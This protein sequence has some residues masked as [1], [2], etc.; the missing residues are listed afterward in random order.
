MT[1]KVV[2]ANKAIGLAPKTENEKRKAERKKR[3]HKQAVYIG[4]LTSKVADAI[5]EIFGNH[6]PTPN[7]QDIT[8]VLALAPVFVLSSQIAQFEQRPQIRQNLMKG[9][10]WSLQ[11]AI[12]SFA[13]P[14]MTTDEAWND[15]MSEE[16]GSDGGTEC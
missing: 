15:L 3:E 11:N 8:D 14:L 13:K 16:G 7:V 4:T 6:E 1:K 2:L 5:N 10:I 12:E 9:A